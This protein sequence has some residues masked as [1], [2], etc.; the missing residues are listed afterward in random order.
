MPTLALLAPTLAYFGPFGGGQMMPL[1]HLNAPQP[2]PLAPQMHLRILSPGMMMGG[3]D[4]GEPSSPLARLM[5]L[6]H[7]GPMMAPPQQQA[8]PF[9]RLLAAAHPEGPTMP[10]Q[11][12]QHPEMAN[13][14]VRLVFPPHMHML[15]RDETP[16]AHLFHM[17]EGMDAH[18]AEPMEV[19]RSPFEM[20]REEDPEQ[21][22]PQEEA[23]P[24]L[25]LLMLRRQLQQ[26]QQQQQQQAEPEEEAPPT[27][28]APFVRVFK[29]G[30]GDEAPRRSPLS[31]LLH[32][33]V[34]S[35]EH[36]EPHPVPNFLH[37]LVS[38]PS[39]P[40]GA[41]LGVGHGPLPG[42][43]GF[44]SAVNPLAELLGS[45]LKSGMMGA[46]Q[47]GVTQVSRTPNGMTIVRRFSLP[48]HDEEDEGEGHDE[49][50]GEGE[51]ES[52]EGDEEEEARPPL[53][54]LFRAAHDG[55]EP[56]RPIS[57]IAELMQS[58]A[59][60]RAAEAIQARRA[61]MAERLE[62]AKEAQQAAEMREK[63]QAM[64][65]T[66][67]GHKTAAELQLQLQ[68]Q[69]QQKGAAQTAAETKASA[70]RQWHEAEEAKRKIHTS[71]GMMK[72]TL[73]RLFTAKEP[74][75]V[76]A[77]SAELY[78]ASDEMARLAAAPAAAANAT[79]SGNASAAPLLPP[80]LDA[81]LRKFL[82]EVAKGL[83]GV[84]R[85]LHLAK[86]D[87][88]YEV[89][90]N[91]TGLHKAQLAVDMHERL[92]K[93]SV[94]SANQTHTVEQQAG[95]APAAEPPAAVETYSIGLPNDVTPTRMAATLKNGTLT[96]SVPRVKDQ[97][98]ALFEM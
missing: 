60:S 91:Y 81:K 74:A 87:D 1:M 34:S 62:E 23:N 32:S 77:L 84:E 26:Q 63:L 59:P 41:H 68:Q 35:P 21:E 14:F 56:P 15:E 66:V 49:G 17:P 79:S 13:P 18:M 86:F 54:F 71:M 9:L 16:A 44:M 73:H 43:P 33:L 48:V 47:G 52:D 90:G 82:A 22:E 58:I 51:G 67:E 42:L 10:P 2:Q 45:A 19:P 4:D 20:P 96:I 80:P 36:E 92:L 5:Q 65:K 93:V 11:Q 69:Q 98:V 39:S 64:R 25:R 29:L 38:A 8:N 97:H 46:P 95:G 40:L 37:S 27:P 88:R 83:H 31:D 28:A 24:L 85:T 53:H 57:R 94:L 55:P 3:A 70:E 6:G 78:A 76:R 7:E 30:G 72:E 61:Q 75:Q 12:P 50:E 89:V